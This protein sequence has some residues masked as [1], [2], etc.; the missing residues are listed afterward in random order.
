MYNSHLKLPNG[1]GVGIA[2]QKLGFCKG[3]IIEP[4]NKMK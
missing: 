2:N 4:L 1:D 3:R